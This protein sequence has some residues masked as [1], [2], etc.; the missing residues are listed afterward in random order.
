MLFSK[1]G[2]IEP[3]HTEEREILLTVT[4]GEHTSL[5]E[6]LLKTPTDAEASVTATYQ[7]SSGGHQKFERDF[8]LTA[9]A[10]DG[11]VLWMPGPIRRV[12]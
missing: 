11:S 5:S 3:G 1:I 12:S 10:V 9:Q 8:A 4:E 7:D 6:F 2:V